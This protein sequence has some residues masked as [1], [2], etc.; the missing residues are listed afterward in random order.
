MKEGQEVG[1]GLETQEAGDS[2]AYTSCGG[3]LPRRVLKEAKEWVFLAG[4][5]V[6]SQEASDA[7]R[8]LDKLS[9]E[10]S[11]S[12]ETPPPPPCKDSPGPPQG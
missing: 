1:V 10:M 3:R 12:R 11:V 8:R 6:R 2:P 9:R 5:K 7:D 4:L